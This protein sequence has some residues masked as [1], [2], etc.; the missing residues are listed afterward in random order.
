M[1]LASFKVHFYGV[2]SHA[3][4][5]PW[6]GVN[7]LDAAVT[8]YNSIAML[9]QQCKPDARIHGIFVDGGSAPNIIPEHTSMYFYVRANETP[10]M[11]TLL[12]KVKRCC[13]CAAESSGC[14]VKFE[15]D[16]ELKSTKQEPRL[17]M[18][19]RKWMIAQGNH[20]RNDSLDKLEHVPLLKLDEGAVPRGSTDMGNILWA[21]PGIHPMYD[22]FPE[23][24]SRE[25]TNLHTVKF[26]DAARTPYAF[27]RTLD[28]SIAL[29]MS[30]LEFFDL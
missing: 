18:L 4:G 2:A 22:I 30:V 26:R 17:G 23:S 6:D 12:S 1:A 16:P 27:E 28:T 9:R 20:F 19:W 25:G 21:Y 29:A 5:A 24:T 13:E 15:D 11:Q 14:T 3:A 10:D 7:A 8:A